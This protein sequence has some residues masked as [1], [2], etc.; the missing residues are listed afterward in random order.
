MREV[1]FRISHAENMLLKLKQRES[2]ENRILVSETVALQFRKII[3]L[4]ALASIAANEEKYAEV[5][6]Q[7]RCDWHARRIFDQLHEINPRFY[8]T[9]IAGLSDPAYEG[10]ASVIE[11]HFSGYLSL[12]EAISLY[13]RCSA[14]LHAENPFGRKID[15][16]ETISWINTIIP[17]LKVLLENF[18]VHL[19]PADRAFCVWMYFE[20]EKD[21]DV[22]LFKFGE[23]PKIAE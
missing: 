4:I 19:S 11:E 13:D 16:D 3:E 7:F 9:P 6:E 18:W 23:A 1:K 8:P 20:Q 5:R 22:A 2:F 15:Y 21:I 10:A 17:L 14:I 12:E